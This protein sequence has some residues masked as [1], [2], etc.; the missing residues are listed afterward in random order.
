MGMLY[1]ENSHDVHAVAIEK[2][3][4]YGQSKLFAQV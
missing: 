4:S 2:E 3:N 1:V